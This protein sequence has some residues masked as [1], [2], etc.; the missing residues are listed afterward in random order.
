ML[1]LQAIF[2]S[3]SLLFSL[4]AAWIIVP[5]G[6]VIGLVFG[7]VP[8]LSVP[9]AMAVFLPA[10][11]YMDFLE[12]ILFLTAIFTG[13]GFGGSIPAILINVPGTSAAIGGRAASCCS[14]LARPLRASCTPRITTN[15]NSR[16]TAAVAATTAPRDRRRGVCG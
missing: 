4:P 13:G 10:T 16:A 15:S 7:A 11:L 9:I 5:L 2:D 14:R 1:D 8:G 3:F 12:S 6:L